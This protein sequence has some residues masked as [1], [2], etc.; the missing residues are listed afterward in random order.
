MPLY[1]RIIFKLVYDGVEHV[2]SYLQLRFYKRNEV[3]TIV[4]RDPDAIL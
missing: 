4:R 1:P 3:F 2:F